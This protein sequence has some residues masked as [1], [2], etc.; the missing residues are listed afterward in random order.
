MQID[1]YPDITRLISSYLTFWEVPNLRKTNKNLSII[2]D[3]DN[4]APVILNINIYVRNEKLEIIE[5]GEKINY[6]IVKP[7][8]YSP[9]IVQFTF[10]S[11]RIVVGHNSVVW[12]GP[13]YK[14]YRTIYRAINTINEIQNDLERHRYL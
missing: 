3:I 13:T 9:I 10:I 5:E 1:K 12:V 4:P 14:K 8:S 11:P 6:N 2:I 7:L